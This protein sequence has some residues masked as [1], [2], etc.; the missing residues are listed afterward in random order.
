MFNYTCHD[1]SFSDGMK[2]SMDI[3]VGDTV[4]SMY[5]ARWTGVVVGLL[6]NDKDKLF[7]IVN[8]GGHG[9]CAVV[10]MTHSSN[11]QPARKQK[12][13]LYS[14]LWFKVIS[15][16]AILPEISWNSAAK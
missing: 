16:D 6:K 3:R 13:Y 4:M 5:R 14:C 7:P 12:L 2:A 15:R 1:G 10:R 9:G 11:G 8:V